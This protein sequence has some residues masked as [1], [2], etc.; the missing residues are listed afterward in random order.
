MG[1]KLIETLSEQLDATVNIVNNHG[2]EIN[3]VFRALI[4]QP[5]AHNEYLLNTPG[6]YA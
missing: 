1:I 3:I 4:H 6:V 5:L 2:V